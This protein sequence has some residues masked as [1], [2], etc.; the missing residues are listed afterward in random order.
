MPR[1]QPR[2]LVVVDLLMMAA[3]G[4]WNW[5]KPRANLPFPETSLS[6]AASACPAAR[7][8]PFGVAAERVG[9]CSWEEKRRRRPPSSMTRGGIVDG[10]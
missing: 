7:A 6:P 8:S 4:G 2:E 5:K 3:A 9:V 10:E 1:Y